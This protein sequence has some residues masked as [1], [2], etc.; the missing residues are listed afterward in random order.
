MEVILRT[1]VEN[2]GR[3]GEIVKV[4]PGYARNYL[5]PQNMAMPATPGNKRLFEQQRKKLQEKLDA[6]RSAAQSLAE[7]LD[8]LSLTIPV[9]VGE[10]D[11][12]YGSVTSTIIAEKLAEQ[13]FEIDKKD[14][15]LDNPIRALGEYSVPV[16]LYP[17]V[18]PE[19]TVSVVRHDE[20]Q[21]RE[22]ERE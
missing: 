15:E 20:G 6:A 18:R 2:L 1:D 11:K 3:L 19:L 8:E 10:G 22:E 5:L 16:R 14:I 17:E 4:K 13:G 21:S 12:L 9:R 7:K